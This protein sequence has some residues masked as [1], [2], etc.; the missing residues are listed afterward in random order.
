MRLTVTIFH[1]LKSHP[2]DIGSGLNGNENQKNASRQRKLGI[3]GNEMLDT[4]TEHQTRLAPD[5]MIVINGE[6]VDVGEIR[7]TSV[8][9]LCDENLVSKLFNTVVAR[10]PIRR[11][12]AYRTPHC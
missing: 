2:C 12:S 4:L 5:N 3:M 10:L 6:L 9:L 11:L 1:R 7:Q 8:S